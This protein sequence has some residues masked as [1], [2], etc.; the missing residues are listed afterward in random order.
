ME[1]MFWDGA[2]WPLQ[3][4]SQGTGTLVDSRGKTLFG[5]SCRGIALVVFMT[6]SLGVQQCR[7]EAVQ[8]P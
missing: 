7:K 3:H 8:F 1:A 6:L 5:S 4:S 2:D